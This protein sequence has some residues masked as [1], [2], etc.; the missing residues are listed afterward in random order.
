MYS[1]NHPAQA[2]QP[3]PY[4]PSSAGQPSMPHID[5]SSSPFLSSSYQSAQG[6]PYHDASSSFF[7]PSNDPAWFTPQLHPSSSTSS[8]SSQAPLQTGFVHY[9]EDEMVHDEAMLEDGFMEVLNDGMGYEVPI[10]EGY[11]PYRRYSE[12]DQPLAMSGTSDRQ[13]FT[14]PH[15]YS[16]SPADSGL[17]QSGYTLAPP[18][19]DQLASYSSSQL[20]NASYALSSSSDVSPGMPLYAPDPSQAAYVPQQPR[21]V[22]G[23]YISDEMEVLQSEHS[24]DPTIYR[25]RSASSDSSYAPHSHYSTS[26]APSPYIDEA[27]QH[28]TFKQPQRMGR[29]SA[30]AS[31][32]PTPAHSAPS[33]RRPSLA[34][35]NTQAA[36]EYAGRDVYASAGPVETSTAVRHHSFSG[37][38]SSAPTTPQQQQPSR[39]RSIDAGDGDYQYEPRRHSLQAQAQSHYAVGQAVSPSPARSARRSSQPASMP[40]TPTRPHSIS[41]R[42][43]S[44]TP[45]GN[46]PSAYGSSPVPPSPFAPSPS[47]SQ[48]RTPTSRRPSAQAEAAYSPL[49]TTTSP[50]FS[51]FSRRH[52]PN[53]TIAVPRTQSETQAHSN[54][55]S[56]PPQSAASTATS[57][58]TNYR[59]P[60]Y[61]PYPNSPFFSPYAGQSPYGTP[62][63]EATGF[64]AAFNGID[65]DC[66]SPLGAAGAAAKARRRYSADQY[67]ASS[68]S[69]QGSRAATYAEERRR[70]S[71]TATF[72][73]SGGQRTV[74]RRA[75]G[76]VSSGLASTAEEELHRTLAA[77]SWDV[78][79]PFET[80]GLGLEIG[81]EEMHL[82][83]PP[84]PQQQAP[85]PIT[86][87]TPVDFAHQSYSSASIPV[88]VDPGEVLYAAPSAFSTT[89][90]EVG[91]LEQQQQ[92]AYDEL[93]RR[94]QQG[95]F[96]VSRQPYGV[97]S[98][99]VRLEKEVQEYVHAEDRMTLGEKTVVILNPKIA[100][101]SYGNEK[102]LLAPP[103]MALLL[104]TSW[105][106]SYDVDPTTPPDSTTASS[107]FSAFKAYTGSLPTPPSLP[108]RAQLAPEVYISISTDRVFPKQPA[109]ISWISNEGTAVIE[110]QEDDAPPIAG[111]AMSKGL[112]VSVPGELNKDVSTTVNAVVTIC[113]PGTGDLESRVWAR[114]MGKP[115]TVIS[116]PSKK[117]SVTAGG[118]SGLHHGSLV[119]LYNRTKTYTGSTRY[120]CTSG[121]QSIFPLHDWHSMTSGLRTRSF[122]PSD[123]RETRF[124]AKTAAWDAF[125]VY[126]VDT[127][128]EPRQQEPPKPTYPKPPLNAVQFGEE[129]KPLYYNQ[130]VVLQDLATGVVS[131]V[132]ILRRID[133]PSLCT[134]GGPPPSSSSSA[135]T[136]SPLR[137]RA[138]HP[139]PRGE[140]PGEPVSQYRPI[141]LQV[142]SSAAEGKEERERE[143][144]LGVVEEEVGV[145]QALEGR[146]Y[147]RS[148]FAKEGAPRTPTT[149]ISSAAQQ[150]QEEQ[151]EGRAKKGRRK[152]A[153]EEGEGAERGRVWTVPLGEHCIWSIAQIELERYSFFVPPSLA[154]ASLVL[155]TRTFAPLSSLQA[156]AD[157][158]C[159]RPP[160]LNPM[161]NSPRPSKPIDTDLPVVR[162]IEIPRERGGNRHFGGAGRTGREEDE[163]MI[164]LHGSHL[165]PALSLTL[166]THPLPP[167][168]ITYKSPTLALIQLPRGVRV[169]RGEKVGVVGRRG[170]GSV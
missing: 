36:P 46:R 110:R 114:L 10:E 142:F 45:G 137:S 153:G 158:R 44:L 79:E 163:G 54:V 8:L 38:I 39:K 131:P 41:R 49:V 155:S 96:A 106:Q 40:V 9:P 56:L 62:A 156:P 22:Y 130:T 164:L 73:G 77:T 28:E 17:F 63:T 140:E 91:I 66:L 124:V 125:V 104:G 78:E 122:A 135:S 14:Q 88:S 69:S 139:V 150:Q 48:P 89:S 157:K 149:P 167:S 27:G 80:V 127:E 76:A 50:S 92:E 61:S 33:S 159:G 121:V 71:A 161:Y 11:Q 128:V 144:F 111:R 160:T 42:R 141:A 152:S 87:V 23:Q 136:S 126:A 154:G 93:F 13:H 147:A 55:A 143:S 75:S 170:M 169:K 31:P 6:T 1:A 4:P 64:S 65:P 53:L 90:A 132:L 58:F 138:A 7:D 148:S 115:I 165:S 94:Q 98:Q 52:H 24:V 102:R 112:A 105:W 30:S 12:G 95:E 81:V 26:L 37:P 74:S 68:P 166:S 99:Q 118:V 84:P 117:R 59:S 5:D 15:S 51:S 60:R 3:P 145:H 35:A 133:T 151:E 20:A 103:P 82:A 67:P 162:Y 21:T 16:S 25:S 86:P 116:K 146:T 129:P 18:P 113:E 2:Q 107:N 119:S 34:H 101:R 19:P 29:H 43:S 85:S 72:A 70:A 134:G 123:A 97:E 32:L 120:L 83:P 168:S 108:H 47:P 109:T 57:S 100:Q